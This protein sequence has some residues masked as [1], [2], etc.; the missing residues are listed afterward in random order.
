M[1]THHIH[2]I[3]VGFHSS[4]EN[5]RNFLGHEENRHVAEEYLKQAEKHGEAHFYTD[6]NKYTIKHETGENGK[7]IFSVDKNHH[8]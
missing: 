7:S 1:D 6:G 8:H 3:E 2:G 4:T 5:A